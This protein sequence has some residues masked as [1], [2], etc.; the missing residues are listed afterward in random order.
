MY[1]NGR[2]HDVEP[3]S[4]VRGIRL[5]PYEAAL[6]HKRGLGR[7]LQAEHEEGGCRTY[8]LPRALWLLWVADFP[9]GGQDAMRRRLAVVTWA[10]KTYSTQEL[11]AI[12]HL[13]DDATEY[14][15]TM[16]EMYKATM[17]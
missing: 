1:V 17:E 9:A 6:F 2:L 5:Q 13:H 4:G 12:M 16:Y 8:K 3:W 15:D 10:A 11:E 14:R 7:L